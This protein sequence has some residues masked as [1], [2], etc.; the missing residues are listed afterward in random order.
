LTK[1]ELGT[2]TERHHETKRDTRLLCSSAQPLRPCS[3][4]QPRRSV[5]SLTHEGG[6]DAQPAAK[7][8]D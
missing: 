6:A 4:N 7:F 1:L 5:S 8:A 3:F 2:T